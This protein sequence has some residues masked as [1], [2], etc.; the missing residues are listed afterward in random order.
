MALTKTGSTSSSLS[1]IVVLA[2]PMLSSTDSDKQRPDQAVDALQVTAIKR[3]IH[4]HRMI[5]F[6][7]RCLRNETI[8]AK[9]TIIRSGLPALAEAEK[10]GGFAKMGRFRLDW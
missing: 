1:S 5:W 8:M 4:K 10:G 6:H 3:S 2:S 9:D 7:D